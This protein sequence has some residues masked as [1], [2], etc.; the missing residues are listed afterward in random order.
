MAK[1]IFGI[2]IGTALVF[3]GIFGKSLPHIPGFLSIGV[4]LYLIA[5][6]IHGLRVIHVKK[7]VAKDKRH[8]LAKYFEEQ[9]KGS[10]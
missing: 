2:I 4:G 7:I 10:E 8:Y 6:N 1:C 9:K 3:F 5:Q